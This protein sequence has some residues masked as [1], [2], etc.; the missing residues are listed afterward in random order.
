MSKGSCRWFI[1]KTQQGKTIVAV[2]SHG[3]HRLSGWENVLVD[4]EFI[5]FLDEQ[6]LSSA[7]E[8]C[9]CDTLVLRAYGLAVVHQAGFFDATEILIN[10][11]DF[12]VVNRTDSKACIDTQL[13]LGLQQFKL[14]T[15]IGMVL[16]RCGEIEQIRFSGIVQQ[17]LLLVL[18]FAQSVNASNAMFS[19]GI[20]GTNV[21][22]ESTLVRKCVSN[23]L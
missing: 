14:P 5:I 3:S 18:K 2:E 9:I 11:F 13:D 17:E 12:W 23:V 16:D 15:E 21:S 4:E 20:E 1:S 19:N 10:C 8:K 7:G 22:S 6:T